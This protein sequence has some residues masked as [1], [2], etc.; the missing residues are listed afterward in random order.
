MDKT[1]MFGMALAILLS[2]VA[3]GLASAA[4]AR[5]S[6]SPNKAADNDCC[7]VIDE[8]RGRIDDLVEDMLVAKSDIEDLKP[9]LNGATRALRYLDDNVRIEGNYGSSDQYGKGA[10][11]YYEGS[12][13]QSKSNAAPFYRWKLSSI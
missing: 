7:A 3:L 1:A 13:K 12:V 6:Y 9:L 8:D 4:Y 10:Y 2:V 5:E 11:L